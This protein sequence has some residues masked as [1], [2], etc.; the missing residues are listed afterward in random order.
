MRNFEVIKYGVGVGLGNAGCG[1]GGWR[2]VRTREMPT[3][4]QNQIVGL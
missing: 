1:L 2:C 3:A 4:A